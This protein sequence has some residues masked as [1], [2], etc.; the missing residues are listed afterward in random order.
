MTQFVGLPEGAA[1]K[2]HL[3]GLPPCPAADAIERVVL[4]VG[5]VFAFAWVLLVLVIIIGVLER[6]APP[7]TRAMAAVFGPNPGTALTELQWHLYA[8][9]FLIAIP[10]AMVRGNHVRID[11]LAEHF[12]L[13]RKAWIELIGT[14]LFLIPF[15]VFVMVHAVPFMERS[16]RLNEVSPSPGGLGARWIIKSFIVS[17]FALLLL[18][19]LARVLRVA[20]YLFRRHAA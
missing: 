20:N 19:A 17:G 2:G 8:A 15:A 4:A 5:K 3:A 11:V 16:I 18:A 9:G 14:L 10:F 13:R 7:I 6:Y 12:P 1:P